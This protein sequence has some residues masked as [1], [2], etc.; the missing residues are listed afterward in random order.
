MSEE[1]KPEGEARIPRRKQPRFRRA[2]I[3]EGQLGDWG[4]SCWFETQH[5]AAEIADWL[6]ERFGRLAGKP[7]AAP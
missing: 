5:E 4:I 6:N 7:E 2:K 1:A 3:Y